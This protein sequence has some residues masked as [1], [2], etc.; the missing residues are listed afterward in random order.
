M[1]PSLSAAFGIV[2]LALGTP[3]YGS[4]ISSFKESQYENTQSLDPTTCGDAGG[5]VTRSSRMA[6]SISSFQR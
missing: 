6:R 1:S 4:L 2:T 3:A 5:K